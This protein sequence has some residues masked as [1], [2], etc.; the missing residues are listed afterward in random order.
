VCPPRDQLRQRRVNISGVG[1]SRCDIGAIEFQRQVKHQDNADSN[2][3]DMDT[4]QPDA[5]LVTAAR[6]TP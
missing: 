5:A 4:D 2:Q 3:P 1:S 6:A